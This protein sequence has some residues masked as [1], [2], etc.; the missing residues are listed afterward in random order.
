MRVVV[1]AMEKNEHLYINEWVKHYLDIG[2]AHVYIYDNDDKNAP[3][4]GCYINQK[5]ANKVTIINIRG[6][7]KE[8]LQNDVYRSFYQRYKNTFDYC[9][10]CDID[11]F[12][13]GTKNVNEWLSKLNAIQVRV[14]W[15]LFGDDDVIKRDTRIPV[16]DFFKKQ[17]TSSLNRNLIDKGDLEIQGK[18]ILRGN[19]NCVNFCS[20]HYFRHSGTGKILQSVLPSGKPCNSGVRIMEDYSQEKIY[21]NHYM[22]KTLDEFINQKLNRN[23]AVFNRALKVDYFWRINKKNKEKIEYLKNM[24][25][26]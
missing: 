3:Y 9:L 21:L 13:M 10:F 4:I 20:V 14:R 19:L 15:K 1:C 2:F 6:F 7:K 23:D 25:L 12:L 26:E 11:E 5:Y 22:T 18:T 16:K 8:K 17:V 24:G